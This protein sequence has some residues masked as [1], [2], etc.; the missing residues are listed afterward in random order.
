METTTIANV[1]TSLLTLPPWAWV[2]SFVLLATS[3][4]LWVV[5]ED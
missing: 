1:L 5:L 2:F 3:A 4:L